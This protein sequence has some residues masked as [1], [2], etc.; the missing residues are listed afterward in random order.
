MRLEDKLVLTS[1]IDLIDQT[2]YICT[3]LD[4]CLRGFSQQEG[5]DHDETLTPVIEEIVLV[6]MKKTR[7]TMI[8]IYYEMQ[9]E[10]SPYL[11]SSGSSCITLVGTW[12]HDYNER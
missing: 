5:E 4:V 2:C 11:K 1:N 3:Q 9:G 6:F 10:K 12:R 7:T 8:H